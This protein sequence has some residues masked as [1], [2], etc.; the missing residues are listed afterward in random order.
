MSYAK[1][2]LRDQVYSLFTLQSEGF[3]GFTCNEA[4]KLIGKNPK[5]LN[6]YKN[7][8]KQLWI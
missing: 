5:D 4:A 7:P 6:N 2:E 3:N 1:N 8:I